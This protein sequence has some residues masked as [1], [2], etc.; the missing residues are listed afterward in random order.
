MNLAGLHGA[1]NVLFLFVQLLA[2]SFDSSCGISSDGQRSFETSDSLLAD[3]GKNS[4]IQKL[5]GLKGTIGRKY[6]L[7]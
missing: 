6:V 5:A 1:G 7:R 4:C 2:P 3:I